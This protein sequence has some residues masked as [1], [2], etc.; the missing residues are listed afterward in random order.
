MARPGYNLAIG[1]PRLAKRETWACP[2]QLPVLEFNYGSHFCH[3]D[4]PRCK[5]T[6]I[7]PRSRSRFFF[8]LVFDQIILALQS[9]LLAALDDAVPV[10][11]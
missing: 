3:L 5:F 6:Q 11:S 9:A 1:V 2:R 4:P 7:R 8:F 10:R